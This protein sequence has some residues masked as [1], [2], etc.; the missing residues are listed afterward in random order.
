MG[1]G[2]KLL[3]RAIFWSALAWYFW[4]FSGAQA[5]GGVGI[6]QM[7]FAV[8]STIAAAFYIVMFLIGWMKSWGMFQGKGDKKDN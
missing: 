8:L 6:I 3:F 5:S 4:F 7:I 2:Y 1:V